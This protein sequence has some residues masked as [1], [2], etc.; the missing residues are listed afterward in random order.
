MSRYN[1]SIPRLSDKICLLDTYY[2]L[3][4]KHG[5]DH[6]DQ[7]Y[8]QADVGNSAILLDEETEHVERAKGDHVA[9][10]MREKGAE[11]QQTQYS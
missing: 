4:A 2:A 5:N 10:I 11:T 8:H 3:A 7:P 1:R 6:S 9:G